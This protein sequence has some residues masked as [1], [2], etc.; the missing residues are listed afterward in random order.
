M[1][2]LYAVLG[3]LIFLSLG[4]CWLIY[5][6][7]G[8]RWPGKSTAV[9]LLQLSALLLPAA[10]LVRDGSL[11]L[12][13]GL[14]EVAFLWLGSRVFEVSGFASGVL[15]CAL[16]V[17]AFAIV[18]GALVGLRLSLV[19]VAL[20]SLMA[21]AIGAGE[22]RSRAAMCQ[23]ALALGV[24]GIKRNSR[25]WSLA[26]APREF[27]FELHAEL[28]RDGQRYGW[29]YGEMAWYLIPD[30]VWGQVRHEKPMACS[31]QAS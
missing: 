2:L 14:P 22:L 31:A 15:I 7:F 9:V 3:I 27:Q 23:E 4:R 17:T 13:L 6:G 24:T 30:N 21:A 25:L 11:L 29:S 16:P 20:V 18:A 19:T 5:R 28:W 26:N 8:G 10:L 12:L 1:I